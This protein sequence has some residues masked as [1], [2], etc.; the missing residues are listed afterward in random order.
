MKIFSNFFSVALLFLPTV[1]LCEGQVSPDLIKKDSLRALRVLDAQESQKILGDHL[2]ELKNHGAADLEDGL[3]EAAQLCQRHWLKNPIASEFDSRP[4]VL[5]KILTLK[6]DYF[7]CFTVKGVTD[8]KVVY[9]G[10]VTKNN[11]GEVFEFVF[12]SF[13]STL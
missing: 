13:V 11:N 4:I 12:R 7:V 3:L 10:R 9:K 5:E 6:N 2:V 8:I 1:F